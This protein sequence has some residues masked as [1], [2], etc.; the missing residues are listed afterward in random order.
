MKLL[1]DKSSSKE[2][3]LARAKAL[4][5]MGDIFQQQQYSEQVLLGKDGDREKAK[6]EE[7][8]K[9]FGMFFEVGA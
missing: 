5:I 6:L 4:H 2:V 9:K 7:R 3:L 8:R 1:G